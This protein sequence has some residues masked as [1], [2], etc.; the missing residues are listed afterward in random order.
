MIFGQESFFYWPKLLH[1]LTSAVL[2]FVY[3][4]SSTASVTVESLKTCSSTCELMTINCGKNLL[5]GGYRDFFFI[6]LI[7]INQ[8]SVAYQGNP[9]GQFVYISISILPRNKRV[10][11]WGAQKFFAS[12]F[13]HFCSKSSTQL[14]HFWISACIIFQRLWPGLTFHTANGI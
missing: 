14:N 8:L 2:Y 5:N 12:Y 6:V 13:V 11:W 10:S 9:N 3:H 7:L 1:L 4:R